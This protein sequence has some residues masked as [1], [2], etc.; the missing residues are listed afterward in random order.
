[1]VSMSSSVFTA[2]ESHLYEEVIGRDRL[3]RP[4]R[5]YAPVGSH[6]TLLAYLVRRLLENGANSSFLNRIADQE[7]AD[8]R[9]D[10]RSGR[11]R[12][13]NRSDWSTARE[14][15]RATQS[16]WIS[17]VNSRGI[18]LSDEMQLAALS[19]GPVIV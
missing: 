10:Q 14:D 7:R 13:R 6:E 15:C 16:L 5:I 8:R 19:E 9:S 12:A 4:C 17:R 2:W 3:N 1:M 11:D 18:D